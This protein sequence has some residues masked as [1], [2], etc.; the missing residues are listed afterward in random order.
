MRQRI[1][2]TLDDKAIEILSTIDN[3]SQYI[4]DL[5]LGS[6]STGN[7]TV[8]QTDGPWVSLDELFENLEAAIKP[9]ELRLDELEKAKPTQS[10][11]F[12]PQPPD[13]E[14]GYPCC[15]KQSPCKHW[16]WSGTDSVWKNTL[17]GKVREP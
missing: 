3:K 12:V 15:S 11:T 13:Q 10:S 16:M 2:I 9:I 17:T 7:S 6:P 1:Q 8:L 5:I 4:E 14:T